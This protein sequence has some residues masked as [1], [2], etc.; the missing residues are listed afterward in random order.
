MKIVKQKKRFVVKTDYSRGDWYQ[1]NSYFFNSLDDVLSFLNGERV[2]NIHGDY[3]SQS[4]HETIRQVYE[5]T[6]YE[7]DYELKKDYEN[8]ADCVWKV[9]E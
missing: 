3:E 1:S 2:K 4:E 7:V 5:E 9:E 6:N 8:I